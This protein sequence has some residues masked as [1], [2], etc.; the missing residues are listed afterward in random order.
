MEE[1]KSVLILWGEEEVD[2]KVK[3]EIDEKLDEI[4]QL[5][6]KK[7]PLTKN[8]DMLPPSEKKI[9]TSA[10]KFHCWMRR[11]RRRRRRRVL[12]Q[13]PVQMQMP[14]HPASEMKMR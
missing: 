9:P 14:T 2:L 11:R 5:D 4:E 13:M 12:I 6:E 7:N 1:E 8:F 10:S 3:R